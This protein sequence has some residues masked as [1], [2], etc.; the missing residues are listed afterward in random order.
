MLILGVVVL[1]GIAGIAAIYM[2]KESNV[3]GSGGGINFEVLG[4]RYQFAAVGVA[5]TCTSDA[6]C[7]TSVGYSA[8]KCLNNYCVVPN[9]GNMWASHWVTNNYNVPIKVKISGDVTCTASGKPNIVMIMPN[10]NVEYTLAAGAQKKDTAWDSAKFD[11]NTFANTNLAADTLTTYTCTVPVGGTYVQSGT[12]YTIPTATISYT[13]QARKD[14]TGGLIV[15]G[16]LGIGTTI[17]GATTTA[18]ATTTLIVTTTVVTTGATTTLAAACTDSDGGQ[19]STV[20]GTTTG[21][22]NAGTA[23]ATP[24]TDTCYAGS[25]STSV[26]EYYCGTGNKQ[27]VV[28][29]ACATGKTC[30][31][32]ACV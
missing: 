8:A 28:Q 31:N 18:G 2:P 26:W 17:P 11:I 10:K 30:V 4:N 1:I 29:I 32:G 19:V 7:V 21:L 20:K 3:T 23:P 13:L 16:G 9:I 6:A 5:M 25:P 22:N 12:T 14:I 27:S 24:A 15:G